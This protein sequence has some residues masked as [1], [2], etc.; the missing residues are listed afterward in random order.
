MSTVV[1]SLGLGVVATVSLRVGHFLPRERGGRQ[2]HGAH[3]SLLCRFWELKCARLF[4]YTWY[5]FIVSCGTGINGLVGVEQTYGTSYTRVG[6]LLCRIRNIRTGNEP[7]LFVPNGGGCGRDRLLSV[8]TGS[9]GPVF[10]TRRSSG[11]LK[12]TF[13]IFRGPTSGSVRPIG[14]LCVSSLYISRGYHNNNIKGQVFRFIGS[15]TGG[16]NYCGLALGI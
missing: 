1:L 10:I 3:S 7:S 13:Y 16:S 14:A 15:C 2:L 8:V 9:R 5:Y 4:S 11:V 6:E 12:C